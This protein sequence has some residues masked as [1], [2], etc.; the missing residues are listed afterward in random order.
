MYK[1]LIFDLDDTLN[2]DTKN[3]QEAFRYLT[4]EKYS[5]EE[6]DK[7]L[8][9]DKN[10]WKERAAGLI[11]DPRD[12]MT[13]KE[14]AE[15]NRAQRFLRYFKNITYDEAVKMNEIYEE[16]LKLNATEIKG[17][18]RTIKY[19]KSKDYKIVIATNG[20]KNAIPAKLDGLGI[21]KEIDEIFS[22]EECGNMKPHTQFYTA[23]FRKINNPELNE[24]LFI[25]DDIEKDIKG[26]QDIGIDTC[27]FNWKYEE[28]KYQPT[29][30][31]HE[32]IELR[33]IL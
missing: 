30:E 6:F 22:A 33:D 24:I 9:I 31:I 32:L 16:G 17:A 2:D 10:Y 26:G 7:F 29:F 3:I 13:A 19:L 11:K 4:K 28:P 21:S 5:D 18:K 12:N 8:A 14:K 25:G 1:T 20:P 15:W 23:L 27:W